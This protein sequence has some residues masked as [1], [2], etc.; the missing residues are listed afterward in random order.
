MICD[1]HEELTMFW[2]FI[3]FFFF[4]KYNLIQKQTSNRKKLRD[5]IIRYFFGV[6]V[7]VEAP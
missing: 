6:S 5:M 2:Q 4:C 7:V 3:V 1:I